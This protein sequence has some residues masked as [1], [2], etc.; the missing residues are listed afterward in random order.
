MC[1]R[2]AQVMQTFAKKPNLKVQ[3]LQD[4]EPAANS[5]CLPV[6]NFRFNVTQYLITEEEIYKR[7][8][9]LGHKRSYF[10]KKNNKTSNFTSQGGQGIKMKKRKTEICSKNT[11]TVDGTLIETMCLID[12][13]QM[14]VGQLLVISRFMA[15]KY[16]CFKFSESQNMF[17]YRNIQYTLNA[18]KKNIDKCKM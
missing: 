13:M 15:Q 2:G 1:F 5:K 10:L 4:L 17:L 9:C 6:D 16:F 12:L 3:Q 14:T 18:N 8:K 11:K 7:K